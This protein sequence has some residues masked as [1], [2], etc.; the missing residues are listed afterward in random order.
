MNGIVPQFTWKRGKRGKK[1]KKKKNMPNFLLKGIPEQSPFFERFSFFFGF[2][3]VEKDLSYQIYD[4]KHVTP[5]CARDGDVTA[6]GESSPTRN[7]VKTK[8]IDF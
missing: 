3:V 5:S 8:S 6:N 2:P 1:K 4:L 7:G